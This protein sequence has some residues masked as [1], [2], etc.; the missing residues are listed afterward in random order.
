MSVAYPPGVTQRHIDEAAG[1]YDEQQRCAVC[2]QLRDKPCRKGD[3]GNETPL[4]CIDCGAPLP[5]GALT[6]CG[7]CEEKHLAA[8]AVQ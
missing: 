2:G 7:E 5:E 8:G 6:L 1:G 3:C 4:R